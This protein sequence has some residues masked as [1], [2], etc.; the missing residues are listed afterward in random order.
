MNGYKTYF[1]A[2]LMVVYA[3]LGF[4]L[5]YGTPEANIQIIL[6]ALIAAG[7]RDGMA[8]LPAKMSV[9]Q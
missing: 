4:V 3:V 7:L 2:A 8:K 9:K 5:G 6:E 1:V